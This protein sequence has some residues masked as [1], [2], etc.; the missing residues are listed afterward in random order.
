VRMSMRR[1]RTGLGWVVGGGLRC[2][3][4]EGLL[5]FTRKSVLIGKKY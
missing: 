5:S 3:G 1:Q 2:G 4:L